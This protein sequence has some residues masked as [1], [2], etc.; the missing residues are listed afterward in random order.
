MLHHNAFKH[1]P[2][3]RSGHAESAITIAVCDMFQMRCCVYAVSGTPRSPGLSGAAA[4]GA[5]AQLRRADTTALD[6]HMNVS[7]Q[8]YARHCH[9]ARLVPANIALLWPGQQG[10]AEGCLA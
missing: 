5:L 6:L 4:Q 10:P 2:F 1:N 9:P 7:F 3:S 8:R